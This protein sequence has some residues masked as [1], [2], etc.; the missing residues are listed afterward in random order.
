MCS[1]CAYRIYDPETGQ[2][3]CAFEQDEDVR[4]WRQIIFP[5]SVCPGYK[6]FHVK[7]EQVK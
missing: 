2:Y 3:D 4:E 5:S 1:L 6:I 7:K